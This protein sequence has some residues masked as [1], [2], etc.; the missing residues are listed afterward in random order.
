MA[1][2]FGTLEE[3]SSRDGRLEAS[4]CGLAHKIGR[5]FGDRLPW[6]HSVCILNNLALLYKEHSKDISKNLL[7]K[8]ILVDVSTSSDGDIEKK[9]V[10]FKWSLT[11]VPD[12]VIDLKSTR[13]VCTDRFGFISNHPYKDIDNLFKEYKRGILK[14]HPAVKPQEHKEPE[15]LAA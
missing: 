10:F 15:K 14:K 13:I 7:D 12:I 3:L 9:Q 11:E 8:P 4:K 1:V 6:Q 5:H 2:Y